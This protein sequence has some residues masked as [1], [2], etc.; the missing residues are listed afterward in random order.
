MAPTVWPSCLLIQTAGNSAGRLFAVANFSG[1]SLPCRLYHVTTCSVD[2]LPMLYS[3]QGGFW[4]RKMLE[5]AKE[6]LNEILTVS[7]S[8]NV[9][10]EFLLAKVKIPVQMVHVGCTQGQ[11]IH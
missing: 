2:W 11:S 10:L 6:F 8:S 4:G 1:P 5:N 9:I 3:I 7:L